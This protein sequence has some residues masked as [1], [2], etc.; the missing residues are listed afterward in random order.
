MTSETNPSAKHKK[1]T[2][3]QEDLSLVEAISSGSI[4]AWHAF[5]HRYSGLIYSIVRRYLMTEDEDEIRTAFV[6][7]LILLYEGELKLY[8]G[9]APLSSWLIVSSRSR[10]ID[11]ARKRHGRIRPPEG[12]EK[13]DLFDK[14]IW[15]LFYVDGLPIEI[16]I[17]TLAWGGLSTNADEILAAIQR[18]EKAVSR[19]Y[20][21]KLDKESQSGKFT[22]GSIPLLRLL[23]QQRVEF[24]EKSR[25]GGADSSLI[26]QEVRE[27]SERL[28]ELVSGLPP[29]E[30][31]IIM[32]RFERGMSARKMADEL[33]MESPRRVY[34][35]INKIVKK[36]RRA[37][38]A[39]RER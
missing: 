23:T 34:S 19:R 4:P 27:K 31:R 6:D 10:A 20:L 33:G 38:A 35:L 1:R 12:Y 25:A 17:H 13:L 7:I 39:E 30:R 3:F 5:I 14:K 18:I 9:D 22:A 2:P 36:L 21:K 37:M 28:L 26:E 16:V 32:M 29:Q 24:E 15:Q 8:R 11:A